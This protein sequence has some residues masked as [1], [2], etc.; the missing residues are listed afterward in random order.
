MA[1]WFLFMQIS[2][3]L[4]DFGYKPRYK[5]ER[6]GELVKWYR[7]FYGEVVLYNQAG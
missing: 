4:D 1:M 2:A 5:A 3:D 7:G 6:W